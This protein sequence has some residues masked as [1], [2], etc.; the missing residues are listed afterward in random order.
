MKLD[1]NRITTR[2]WQGSHPAPGPF[3]QQ[4]GA[5]VLVLC[6]QERQHPAEHYP[7][8]HVIHAPMDD[9]YTVPTV[10]ATR[11]AKLA[12]AE[13]RK[14]ARILVCCNQGINRSGLVVAIMLTMLTGVSGYEAV[15]R[16]QAYRLGAL[17]NP[18]F[19]MYLRSIP[20]R[21]TIHDLTASP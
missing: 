21:N 10:E 14:G 7:G 1:A 17:I 19:T 11:A 2:I 16:V 20:D 3:V 5:N 8:V 12:L 4:A 13:H 15:R 18:A 6:A 9:S